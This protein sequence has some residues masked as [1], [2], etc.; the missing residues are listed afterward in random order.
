M[1]NEKNLNDGK[2]KKKIFINT[3]FLP[4]MWLNLQDIMQK[5][6]KNDIYCKYN[7]RNEKF[8]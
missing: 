3:I 1:G 8:V 4:N 6:E 2:N 5:R 7:V